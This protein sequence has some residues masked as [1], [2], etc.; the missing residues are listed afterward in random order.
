V[1]ADLPARR[2]S[3]TPLR[4]RS[5]RTFEGRR[6]DQS[7]PAVWAAS[8]WASLG[9]LPPP[10]IPYRPSVAL[11]RSSEATTSSHCAPTPARGSIAW[12]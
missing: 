9:R 12:I 2:R 4:V 3:V 11:P 5:T 1:G 10:R 8:W 7:C 6:A